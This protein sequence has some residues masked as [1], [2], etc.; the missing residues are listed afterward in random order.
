MGTKINKHYR[1]TLKKCWGFKISNCQCYPCKVDY[2]RIRD[3]VNKHRKANGDRVLMN[4]K[5][6][7]K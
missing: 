1:K 4:N 5:N 2:L 6:W 3:T 7:S